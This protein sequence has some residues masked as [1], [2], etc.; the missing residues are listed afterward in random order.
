MPRHKKCNPCKIQVEPNQSIFHACPDKQCWFT[1]IDN[2]SYNSISGGN[3]DFNGDSNSDNDDS[4]D[5]NIGDK[6]HN[7][8]I[9]C[10]GDDVGDSSVGSNDNDNDDGANR[11]GGGGCG[12]TN[13][14]DS[15]K[16]SLSNVGK[17]FFKIK[18]QI[19]NSNFLTLKIGRLLPWI[20]IISGP[21]CTTICNIWINL[22]STSL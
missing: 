4:S 2:S 10:G 17:V 9:G 18:I 19:E 14:G 1:Y 13:I 7:V 22:R 16:E 3:F 11:N 12:N 21:L 5:N 8:S 6:D 20:T 15:E